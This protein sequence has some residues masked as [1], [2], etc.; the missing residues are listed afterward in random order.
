MPGG[1][2][3]RRKPSMT[4]AQCR[5]KM[6]SQ[7]A[8]FAVYQTARPKSW[9]NTLDVFFQILDQRYLRRHA[10]LK[11]ALTQF[12][13]HPRM[14]GENPE[15]AQNLLAVSQLFMNTL[16]LTSCGDLTPEEM[17]NAIFLSV[18]ESKLSRR[19]MDN[20]MIQLL[21][22]SNTHSYYGAN[23]DADQGLEFLAIRTASLVEL[24]K[25]GKKDKKAKKTLNL[26]RPYP[27]FGSVRAI[28]RRLTSELY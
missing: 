18:M 5:K 4:S 6:A 27:I 26:L 25:V 2:S 10:E 3:Q 20:W 17:V 8:V 13:A 9:Q 24:S 19:L 21:S 11:A 1:A 23:V 14:T 12:M 28:N 7:F 15:Q 16:R 22:N